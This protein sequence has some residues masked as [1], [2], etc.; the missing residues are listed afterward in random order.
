M[1]RDISMRVIRSTAVALALALTALAATAANAGAYQLTVTEAE[2][3][4]WT[5]LGKFR[6]ESPVSL[7][8]S[9][10]LEPAPTPTVE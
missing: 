7:A 5:S 9:F 10:A 1:R 4:S 8:G 2:A 6:C 3:L